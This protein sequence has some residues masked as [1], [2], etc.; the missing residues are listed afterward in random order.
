MEMLDEA[1]QEKMAAQV[2]KID[3]KMLDDIKSQ[4]AGGVKEKKVEPLAAVELKDIELNKASYIE[5]GIRAIR[6]GEVAAVLLAGGQ[7]TRLGLDKPKGTLNIGE[8]KDLYLFEQLIY[9]LLDVVNKTGAYIPLYIMTSEKNNEDTEAFFKEHSFFGYDSSFVTFF[10][11]NMA[12]S[13]DYN[14]KLY[15][16]EKDS[17]A[18]SPNGNGGWFLSMLS[19]GLEADLKKRGVKWINVFAVDNILQRIADPAFV[20]ATIQSG[21]SCGSKVVRKVSPDEKVGVMCKV[22]GHPSIIEYYE[23]SEELANLRREDGELV[24]GFGVTLNYLFKLDTLLEIADKKLPL[25]IVEKKIPYINEKGELI[26]PESPNGYKFETLVLDM[27]EMMD[28]CVPYE[29]VREH[30]FAPIKNKTGKD[31][32]ESAKKLLK[33]NGIEF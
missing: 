23:M 3:W 5:T 9:N 18:M 13:V 20:G 31:S 12:P 22:N 19:A 29:V 4:A 26:K 30:E 24:Y 7:G 17:L 2:A 15:M 32:I 25:H 16:E 33:L 6:E 27:V 8:Q 14:G 21:C 28:N 10:V 1:G 11:Q